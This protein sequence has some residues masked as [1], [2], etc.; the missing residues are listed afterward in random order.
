[1]PG[2]DYIHSLFDVDLDYDADYAVDTE[3]TGLNTYKG[4]LPYCIPICWPDGS[5]DCYEWDVDPMTRQ[6]IFDATAHDRRQFRAVK[7][8]LE[9]HDR[10]P[11]LHHSKHDIKQLEA[12]GIK[13]LSDDPE[14]PRR[15]HDT[16][17]MSHALDSIESHGLND[18][19]AKYFGVSEVDEHLMMS[20]IKKARRKA[21]PLGWAI[22]KPDRKVDDKNEG[23]WIKADAWLMRALIKHG[24][25]P[26]DMCETYCG[27]DKPWSTLLSTYAVTDV[28]LR[29]WPVYVLL[30]YQLRK[31][32]LWDAYMREMCLLPATLRTERRGLAVSS[33]RLYDEQHKLQTVVDEQEQLIQSIAWNT[34][35]RKDVESRTA[36]NINSNAKDLPQLLYDKLRLPI[37][38]KTKGGNPSTSADT[39]KELLDSGL[40]R[41][42]CFLCDESPSN[43][44]QE[45]GGKSYIQPHRRS[46]ECILALMDRQ[47]KLTAIKYLRGYETRA[48]KR[49]RVL[50]L[51][52]TINQTGTVSTRESSQDPNGQNVGRG[53]GV[54]DKPSLRRVFIPR[55]GYS[56]LAADWDQLELRLSAWASQDPIMLQWFREG[57]DPHREIGYRVCGEPSNDDEAKLFRYAG[58]TL[59]YAVSYEAGAWLLD[60]VA[61]RLTGKKSGGGGQ[62]LLNM[63]NNE[64]STFYEWRQSVIKLAR[65]GKCHLSLSGTGFHDGPCRCREPH[66]HTL[67][68]YR[69]AIEPRR[70]KTTAVNAII[71]GSNGDMLKRSH[72]IIDLMLQKHNQR[73]TRPWH[74]L[75]P[76]HDEL[77]FEMP[78]N[79][80]NKWIIAQRI[81]DIMGDTDGVV[82]IDTPSSCKMSSDSWGDAV[83]IDLSQYSAV[84]EGRYSG[85]VA[86]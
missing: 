77:A 74:I 43:D 2:M 22:S 63:Y 73:L 46:R 39:L 16:M 14:R 36:L 86:V 41:R 69:L 72:T 53:G 66:V 24:E 49:G 60:E 15:L 54:D 25:V 79:D 59:N 75:M 6:P 67:F 5:V 11:V 52:P 40:H 47:S 84:K 56:W 44:C 48:M 35:M 42:S 7:S 83:E 17:Y 26:D 71:Q 12:V 64:L 82:G 51:H 62:R 57:R 4:E 1:M 18:I 8:L 30:S 50:V 80:K 27:V 38:A 29:T 13:I 70:A 28:R 81:V 33:K 9:D 55:K 37:L 34:G 68:G 32:G 21:E 3:S 10:V 58:K 78:N 20:A 85:R 23:S 19:A 45:C 76:I 31:Q 61:Q 65:S